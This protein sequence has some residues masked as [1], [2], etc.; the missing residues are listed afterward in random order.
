MP[1]EVGGP[2]TVAGCLMRGDQV[3]GGDDDHY[4]LAR[5]R[6]GP[7]DSVPEETCTADV[8]ADALELEDVGGIGITDSLIGRWVEISGEL[9]RE[10]SRDPDN[11]RELDVHAFR[12]VPVVLPRAAAR[13][14]APPVAAQRPP[15]AEPA[16][17][18]GTTLEAPTSLPKTASPIPA[19]GLI[20]LLSLG[21]ALV[22][23]RFRGGHRG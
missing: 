6:I 16:E 12:V 21:G 9:E 13:P 2:I 11:L 19:I 20:G 23:R 22:L 1:Q 17:P 8:D 14:S 15:I 5:P 3:R 18:V 10:T 4:V 7:I